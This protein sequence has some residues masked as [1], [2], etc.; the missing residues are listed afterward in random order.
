[1]IY[2]YQSPRET[3]LLKLGD[4]LFEVSCSAKYDFHHPPRYKRTVEFPDN[5]LST[6]RKLP[7]PFGHL[8]TD[9]PGF[10]FAKCL[11]QP[12]RKKLHRRWQ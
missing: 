8:L 4:K 3:T 6:I 5:L 2:F 10:Y 1:M 7:G 12:E 9:W 11:P